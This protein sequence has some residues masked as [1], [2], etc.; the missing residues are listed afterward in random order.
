M[1]RTFLSFITS[2]VK[3]SRFGKRFQQ[4]D[5]KFVACRVANL[6]CR[7]LMNYYS[8]QQACTWSAAL[9]AYLNRDKGIQATIVIN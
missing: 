1:Y 7:Y 6:I 9:L 2:H 5:K 3:I 4:Q 8:M